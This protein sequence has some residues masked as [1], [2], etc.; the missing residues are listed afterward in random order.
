MLGFIFKVKKNNTANVY[1]V[2]RTILPYIIVFIFICFAM[3]VNFEWVFKPKR[4]INIMILALIFCSKMV[5][6]EV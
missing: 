6:P 3:M 4:S 5:F 2:T 1:G